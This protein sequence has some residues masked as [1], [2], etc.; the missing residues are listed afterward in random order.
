MCEW[1]VTL[2]DEELI[3]IAFTDEANFYLDGEVNSRNCTRYIGSKK[4]GG[5]GRAGLDVNLIH[6]K[7]KHAEKLMV[8]AGTCKGRLFGLKFIHGNMNS[9]MYQELVK[10]ECIPQLMAANNGS[11]E[12]IIW[13]QDG[14][15]IHRN[16]RF[17]EYL[18]Q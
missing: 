5:A 3:N 11:L 18:D 6:M 9:Q 2:S 4:K 17:M 15:T 16:P 14:A 1:L 10:E 13:Q 7:E 12:G 8:F